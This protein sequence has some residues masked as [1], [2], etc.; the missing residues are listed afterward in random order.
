[1]PRHGFWHETYFIRGGMEAVYDDVP[2]PTG[3]MR[4][5]PIQPARGSLFSARKRL[6]LKGEPQGSDPILEGEFYGN[7]RPE[8]NSG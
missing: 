2:Q 1:M 7:R 4:F 5:A 3:F 6:G 8:E